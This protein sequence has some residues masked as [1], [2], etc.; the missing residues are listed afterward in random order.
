ML[1][2][3]KNLLISRGGPIRG[4]EEHDDEIKRL[5]V[6]RLTLVEPRHPIRR[7]NASIVQPWRVNEIEL[8]QLAA[9]G[10]LRDSFYRPCCLE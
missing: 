3:T 5:W 7:G 10:H 4:L 9:L 8:I 2:D 6:I 1:T